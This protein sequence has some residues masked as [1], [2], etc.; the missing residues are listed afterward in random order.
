MRLTTKLAALEKSEPNSGLS[1]VELTTLVQL[2]ARRDALFWPHRY[3]DGKTVWMAEIVRRQ[4]EY[5]EGA[6]GLNVKADG[7]SS[8]KNTHE[9]RQKL[10]G[11]GYILANHSGGQV[12][13]CFLTLK[14]EATARALVGARLKTYGNFVALVVLQYLRKR[15]ER[16]KV[17]TIRESVLFR[18][19]LSGSPSD[20]DDLTENLLPWLACGCVRCHSDSQGRACYAIVDSVPI[21]EVIKVDLVS[22]PVFD[23]IYLKAYESERINLEST[24]PRDP[25]ALYIPLPATGWGW[26]CYEDLPED[27][28]YKHPAG[29][30]NG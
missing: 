25:H 30:V 14:G 26:P 10:I 23:D 18:K 1:R 22:D 5:L 29:V 13:N 7:K 11:G 6:V 17:K 16:A 19:D 4:K 12:T 21:P 28:P 3:Q 24:E 8:W 27:G 9:V 20:W 2:L 15:W